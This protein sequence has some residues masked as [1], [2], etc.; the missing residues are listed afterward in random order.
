[1]QEQQAPMVNLGA[2][3]VLVDW[4]AASLWRWMGPVRPVM[5]ASPG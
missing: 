3:L 5:R 1:M 4:E 2:L